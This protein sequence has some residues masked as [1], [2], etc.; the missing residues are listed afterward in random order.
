MVGED[1]ARRCRRSG[2]RYFADYFH[3]YYRRRFNV[4]ISARRSILSYASPPGVKMTLVTRR[5]ATVITLAG[6]PARVIEVLAPFFKITTA[7]AR[8]LV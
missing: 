7:H 8:A 6:T 4:C 3:Y 5:R 1:V 2:E